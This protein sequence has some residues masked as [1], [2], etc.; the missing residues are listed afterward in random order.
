MTIR[1]PA[2]AP[3]KRLTRDVDSLNVSLN[4]ALDVLAVR[5]RRDKAL[6]DGDAENLAEMEAKYPG[7]Q[8][9]LLYTSDAADE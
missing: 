4:Q 6:H 8:G 3:I 9:C 7:L 2:R 1:R 5:A